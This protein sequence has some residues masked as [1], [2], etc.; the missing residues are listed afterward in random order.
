[1]ADGTSVWRREHMQH[2]VH[3]S[4]DTDSARVAN[5]MDPATDAVAFKRLLKWQRQ[6]AAYT[7][8]TRG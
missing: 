6:K 4:G 3:A 8:S 2:H 1:V 5:V 7:P